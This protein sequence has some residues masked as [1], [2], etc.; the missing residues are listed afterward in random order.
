MSFFPHSSLCFL[1]HIAL[2]RSEFGFPPRDFMPT[3]WKN[4]VQH[5]IYLTRL[6]R[7]SQRS[8]VF[9]VR[10]SHGEGLA[11]SEEKLDSK[12]IDAEKKERVDLHATFT[13]DS[14]GLNWVVPWS[15]SF[16]F[17][18]IILFFS[19]YRHFCNFCLIISNFRDEI[20]FL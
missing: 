4:A 10:V 8:C 15:L 20:W 12:Q 14:G 13:I 16:F 18:H 2:L 9:L 19:I 11:R 1:Y 6:C 5:R 17:P 3:I 7:N